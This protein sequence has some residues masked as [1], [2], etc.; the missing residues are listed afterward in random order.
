MIKT[1]STVIRTL[2]AGSRR[3]TATYLIDHHIFEY[4]HNALLHLKG[5]WK[6]WNLPKKSVNGL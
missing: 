2:F 4:P 1:D 5:I 6:K 3:F